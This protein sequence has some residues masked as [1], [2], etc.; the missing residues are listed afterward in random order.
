MQSKIRP[1][2]DGVSLIAVEYPIGVKDGAVVEPAQLQ[3][4]K[5]QLARVEG[6]RSP[7]R[8]PTWS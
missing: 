5:D 6:A 3:G 4:A 1:A 7:T 8:S 2:V